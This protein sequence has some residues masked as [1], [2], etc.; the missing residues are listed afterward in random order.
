MPTA[1]SQ[2]MLVV[3][4]VE[5]TSRF[6]RDLLGLESRHG[7]SEYDQ[8]YADDE[9]VMQLHDRDEDHHHESLR[10][11]GVPVGNGVLVWF[12]VADFDAVVARARELDAEIVQDV[13]VNPNAQQREL[14]IRDP[15]GY[16]VVLAGPSAYR[17]RS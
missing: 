3:D 6:Y 14:W 11:D 15:D 2:L 9:M 1:W 17:P 13:H 16:S 5:R 7:G 8:L 4:D 12:E 10:T